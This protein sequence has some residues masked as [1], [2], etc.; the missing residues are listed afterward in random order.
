M[1]ETTKPSTALRGANGDGAFTLGDL[2]ASAAQAFFVPGD[3]LIWTTATYA[4]PVARFLEIGPADYGGLVSGVA[5]GLIW[6]A[7]VVLAAV[8]TGIVRDL[9]RRLTDSLVGGWREARRRLRVGVALLGYRWRQL[10]RAKRSA[11]E[12]IEF[13]EE[14]E[15]GEAE[16]RALRLHAKL[17]PGYSLGVSDVAAG[18]GVRKHEARQ[19]LSRLRQLQ[20]VSPTLGGSGDGENAY[21]ATRAGRAF[22]A[23]RQPSAG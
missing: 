14:P 7:L 9:D 15:V 12:V 13:S 22:V 6:L 3:W 21:T 19:I 1:D 11:A 16:L 8:V 17:Q 23:F 2:P 10:V 18:L 5:S 4:P 20:F